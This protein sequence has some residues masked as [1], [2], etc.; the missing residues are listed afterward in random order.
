MQ[1]GGAQPPEPVRVSKSTSKRA[2]ELLHFL[3]LPLQLTVLHGGRESVSRDPAKPFLGAR[4]LFLPPGSGK[5][6]KQKLSYRRV[7]TGPFRDSFTAQSEIS[8]AWAAPRQPLRCGTGPE[9]G[10]D[11]LSRNTC[12]LVRL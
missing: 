8:S 10:A 4:G 3:R 6:S 9:N 2:D 5:D 12:M 11:G 1:F 7:K